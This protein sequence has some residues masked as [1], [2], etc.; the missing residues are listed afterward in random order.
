MNG[1]LYSTP[2]DGWVL[3]ITTCHTVRNG[4]GGAIYGELTTGS[5]QKVSHSHGFSTL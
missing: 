3:S 1:I 4:A 5:M 2:I